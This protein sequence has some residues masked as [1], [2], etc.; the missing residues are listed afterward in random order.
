MGTTVWGALSTAPW[1]FL[2]SR[3]P[4]LSLVYLASSAVLGF[5]L[6][7]AIVATVLF[8]PLWGIVVSVLERRRIRILGFASLPSGHAPIGADRRYEWIGIRL[9]EAAT[10]REVASLLATLLAGWLALV[11]LFAEA[12]A[13]VALGGMIVVSWGGPRSLNLF[14]DVMWTADRGSMWILVVGVVAVLIVS[15]YLNAFLASAQAAL[16]RVLLAPRR[17]ELERVVERL[18]RSRETLVHA[19]E[20]ERRRIERD[21]HDGV[22]QEL[23]ALS[24]RLGIAGL[25]LDDAQA[26]GADVARARESLDA[27]QNQAEQALASLR[28]SVRGIH[29]VVLADH[30]LSAALHELAGRSALPLV[31]R[32]DGVHGV[33]LS[34]AVELCAYFFVTEATTNAAKHTD[35]THLD[36]TADVTGSR[37]VVVARDDGDGG[38]SDE[39]G[40]GLRGLGERA[41]T[42][43]GVLHVDSPAGGPTRLVLD[44][45]AEPRDSAFDAPSEGAPS[46]VPAASEGD[47]HAHLPR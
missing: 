29:P 21:L 37:L 16:A 34:A 4:W 17:R 42:L 44:L 6:L 23:V 43:G 25:E 32:T 45:P 28:A 38:A 33:R 19:F 39:G 11:V 10:W 41:A 40:T 9:T 15:A 14:G 7:G 24:M 12:M 27:A 1:R 18:T 22:Q 31:L 35:A 5:A 2:A 26:A 13:L 47:P 3:W 36:V 30:G 20:H 46:R 8:L